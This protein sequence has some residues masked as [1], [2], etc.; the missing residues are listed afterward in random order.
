MYYLLYLVVKSGNGTAAFVPKMS[1]TSIALDLFRQKGIFGKLKLHLNSFNSVVILLIWILSF[2]LLWWEILQ[3]S[4]LNDYRHTT[5]TLWNFVICCLLFTIFNLTSFVWSM[6]RVVFGLYTHRFSVYVNL[7][8]CQTSHTW[9]VLYFLCFVCSPSVYY[10]I[11]VI[12]PTFNF[13]GLYKGLGATMLRDVSFSVVYFPL[14]ANLNA[15]GPKKVPLFTFA[16]KSKDIVFIYCS[17]WNII[18][19]G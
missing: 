19:N 10:E 12:L 15:M 8:L 18:Y 16:W 1:A 13:S 6:N 2:Y 7:T 5:N 17:V 4:Y 9:C 14:F 11:M 3:Y